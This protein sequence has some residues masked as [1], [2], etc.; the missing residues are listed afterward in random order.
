MRL[1]PVGALRQRRRAI[2]TTTRKPASTR[3][4]RTRSSPAPTPATGSARPIP[5]A[6]GGRAVA[7][8]RPQ[9]HPEL[10]ALVEGARASPTS[11][12]RARCCSASAR[13]FDLTP[14]LRVS[15]T[16]TTSGSR[17]PPSLAGAAQR[18]RR[19]RTTIGWDLSVAAIWRPHD[20]P[21]HRLP[22]R[23]P[24]RSI[25]GK[26][27][28]DLF[29]NANGDTH[30]YSMLA[31]RDPDATDARS[32]N[33]SRV[34][35]LS[36]AAGAGGAQ[37]ALPAVAGASEGE[38]PRRARTTPYAPARAGAA[39]PTSE[40]D[41]KSAGCVSLP[42]RDATRTTMHVDPAVRAGLHRLPRRRRRGRRRRPAPAQDDARAMSRRASKAHV[43]P[44]YPEELALPVARANPEAQLHA[45]EPRG[46]GVRPLRQSVATTASRARPAA[47]AT[48]EVIEAAERSLMA[49]GRD[50]VGRRGLQ[51]RHP[52]VQELHPR[53]GLHARRRA[54]ADRL[55]G[56]AARHADRTSR[57]S[58]ARWPTL[59]PLPPW[60][61]IP[62]GDVFRVFERGGRNID[63]QFPEIGL[64]NPTGSIQRLEEPGRPD[65]R[66]SNRGPGT[67]LRIAI[68]VLNIHKTRLNDPFT[69][70][71]GHQRPAGRLPLSRAARPATSSTPT[72]ASRAHSLTYAQYGHDGQTQTGRPDR[73]P[74]GRA[75]RPPDCQARR[76]RARSRP[77]SA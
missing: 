32:P 76:S 70:V 71:H 68:P 65:I 34:D 39:R 12:I 64:P 47:P 56:D 73:S 26:G 5:F 14:E 55:A 45:A 42:H 62:P 77:R 57:R 58:A 7:R 44:R 11:T 50:A 74:Q 24:R 2:P 60:Q 23:R 10:A 61:V 54:G 6:G 30:Y 25:P 67:G 19:S 52:A 75:S 15:P 63:T 17:T 38:K 36:A 35:R 72:T 16:P 20:D 48:C 49:T 18:R 33:T 8:Q 41:A 29:A 9:R 3:S 4:S 37:P 31:Q 66:Q 40:A 43:L 59:Y 1:A 46:A 27:F 21:E 13:D 22:R 53:R 69:V 28:D 51:Q